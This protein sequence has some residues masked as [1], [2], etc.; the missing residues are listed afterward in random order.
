M[1]RFMTVQVQIAAFAFRFSSPAFMKVLFLQIL[2]VLPLKS[3]AQFDNRHVQ[4]SALMESCYNFQ[5]ARADSLMQILRKQPSQVL[6]VE[7]DLLE[8]N[9]IWWKTISGDKDKKLRS[10]FFKVLESA[11]KHTS[12]E[13]KYS[14]NFYIHQ[15]SIHGFRTRMTMLD[16]SYAT[17]FFQLNSSLKLFEHLLGKEQENPILLIFNGLYHYYWSRSWD[18]YFLLRPYLAIFPTG[19]PQLGLQML[20]RGSRSGIKSVETEARYF[21]MK[22]FFDE[23]KPSNALPYA[24][25]LCR[26]YPANSVFAYYLASILRQAGQEEQAAACEVALLENLKRNPEMNAIQIQHFK[27]LCSRKDK[28]QVKK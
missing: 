27:Q 3:F 18:E 21:L 22:I 12:I 20:E 17:A 13:K 28:K 10:K 25:R 2:F 16:Q 11:R 24:R 5:F 1:P 14:L 7:A 4:A 15:L 8:A 19:S 26:D 6:P 9:L 23:G